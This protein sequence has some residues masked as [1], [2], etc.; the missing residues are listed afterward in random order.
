MVR[1]CNLSFPTGS[2]KNCQWI[3]ILRSYANMQIY[4]WSA[5]ISH[6][7]CSFRRI[8]KVWNLPHET[9][10]SFVKSG[11][12]R[13]YSMFVIWLYN[14]TSW[15]WYQATTKGNWNGYLCFVSLV[16][17]QIQKQCLFSLDLQ[18]EWI[19]I[20]HNRQCSVL[21]LLKTKDWESCI[22][23]WWDVVDS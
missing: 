2:K 13:N 14:M 17:V 11:A 22:T 16:E 15:N 7:M 3:I 10:V 5:S 18:K 21:Q 19:T 8:F 23:H 4:Y 20:G 6:I 9:G 1:I 12:P